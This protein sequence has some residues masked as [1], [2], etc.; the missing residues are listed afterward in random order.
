MLSRRKPYLICALT[1]AAALAL[2]AAGCGDDDSASTAAGGGSGVSKDAL[3]NYDPGKERRIAVDDKTFDVPKPSKKYVIGVAFP[4]FKDPYWIAE[5]YGVKKRADELGVDVRIQGAKGYGDTATQMQQLDTYMT[6]NVDG[7]IL[8]AVDSKGIAPAADRAWNQ[9]IPVAYAN[10]LAESKKSMGVY[11]DDD[12]AGVRQADFVA[13]QDPKAQVIAFCGPPGVIWPKLRCEG[14]ERELKEKA[15]QARILTKKFHDMDRAKI[16]DIASN[17]LEAFPKATWVFNSTDLQAKGVIDAL[18]ARG[19]K[20]GE[21][22]ITNLTIG[23]ELFGLMKQG[24]ITYALSER[25]VLQG[26]LALDQLIM[27]LEGEKPPAN[28][29]IDLPGFEG[30]QADIARFE[31][32]EDALNWSPKGYRP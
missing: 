9:G 16:A 4:H 1:A 11:T 6:Q 27:V 12:L 17:T 32:G 20:P 29:A 19:K 7:I 3:R 22:K 28:W 25:A 23:E 2:T 18:R 31:Q 21:I 24:W 30:N 5:A 8:G 26:R 14:F 10:A 15:P 13:K